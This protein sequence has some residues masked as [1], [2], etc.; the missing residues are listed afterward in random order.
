MVS[1]GRHQLA[2]TVFG[3]G[4]PT[5]VIEPSF[6]GAAEDWTKIAQQLAEDMTIVTYDRA[7]YGASSPAQDARTPHDIA[8]DLDGLLTELGVTGALVLGGRDLHARLRGRAP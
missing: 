7:P 8:A 5:V 2:A 4:T 1:V 3:T 6:G